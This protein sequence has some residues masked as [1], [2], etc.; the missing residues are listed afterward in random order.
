MAGT[1]KRVRKAVGRGVDY[2]DQSYADWWDQINAH[3][4]DMTHPNRC[5][6]GQ[7]DESYW[8]SRESRDHGNRWLARRGFGCW[9]AENATRWGFTPWE[10]LTKEWR[11]RILLRQE[12]TRKGSV[13]D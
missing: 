12:R 10:M 8:E 1:K 5:V 3:S 6:L 11:R 4:L 9:E 13:N 7:L 2:L